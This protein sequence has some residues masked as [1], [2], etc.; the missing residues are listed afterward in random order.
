M[1]A[2]S[3]LSVVVATLLVTCGPADANLDSEDDLGDGESLDFEAIGLALLER[4]EL[5]QGERLL[6]VGA[7]GRFNPLVP[8]LLDGATEAGTTSLGAWAVEGEQV[9]GWSTAFTEELRGTDADGL[10]EVL[11]D[12]DVS[13]M[14]PGATPAHPIYAALQ[15]VLRAGRGRTVHFHWLGAYGLNGEELPVDDVVDRLYQRVLLD[16]DYAALASVQM[17]FEEAVRGMMPTDVRVTTPAGTDISFQVG[18]RPVTRQDGDASAARAELARNLI[19]REVELPAGAIRVAPV[20]ESVNGR[21][22][23]PP[24][25]WG[26][27]RVEGLVLTFEAGRV[28]DASAESGLEAVRAELASAEPAS[29]SFREFALGFNPLL[30]VVDDEAGSPWI[31][32]YGYGAGVVRLSLG[33]NSELGGAVGGGYVR[34]NFF[35]DATVTVGDDVW[36]DGGRLVR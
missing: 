15:D 29:N 18:D 5:Q 3:A 7:P 11:A 8:I 27:E 34:W 23:F 36:V 9:D 26:G 17:A 21:I 13:V 28:V 19:D 10:V 4:M 22:A 1:P 32:Y 30:A 2:R 31:P 12:V 35:T 16:T 33:D 20:E 24:S 14:L 6:L 25:V